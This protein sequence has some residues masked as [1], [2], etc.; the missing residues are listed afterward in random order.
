[1]QK[2]IKIWFSRLTRTGKILLYSA[3]VGLVWLLLGIINNIFNIV[4]IDGALR[5]VFIVMNV[6]AIL[7]IIFVLMQAAAVIYMMREEN[8]MYREMMTKGRRRGNSME[9]VGGRRSQASMTRKGAQSQAFSTGF[10][11]VE[12]I[13]QK[14]PA[15]WH[16]KPK[17][18]SEWKEIKES[19]IF[20]LESDPK[21]KIE[22]IDA[23]EMG[24]G[25][26]VGTWEGNKVM[27]YKRILVLNKKTGRPLSFSSLRN[28]KKKISKLI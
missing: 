3:A 1:M 17:L 20:A 10:L 24:G 8:E 19:G 25:Y 22:I 2:D 15:R 6:I 16:K 7:L 14:Y 13:N 26:F 4:E 18:I 23:T 28:A 5:I 9:Q 11:T 21:V 12:N 27:K